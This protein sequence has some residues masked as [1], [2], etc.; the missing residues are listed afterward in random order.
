MKNIDSTYVAIGATWLVLGMTL[1]IVMGATNNFQFM[2]LHAHINLIGFTCHAIFGMAY[3][4]WP[5]MKTSS[6]APYQFWIFILAAPIT[7]I[8]LVFTLNGGPELPTIIGSL[9]VLV[10]AVLFCVMSWQAR[11]TG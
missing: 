9:G 5:M 3:R 10:G 8:G 7:L 4:H 2:P 1:G 6:L 11:A